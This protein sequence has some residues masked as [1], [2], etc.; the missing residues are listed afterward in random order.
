MLG[1]LRHE[2]LSLVTQ[3]TYLV[4]NGLDIIQD[5]LTSSLELDHGPT[6]LSN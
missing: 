4:R 1:K 6:L 3:D 5:S 2:K